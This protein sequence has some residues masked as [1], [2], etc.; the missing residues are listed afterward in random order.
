MID[1][2]VENII[3][4]KI[5]KKK[6]KKRKASYIPTSI[7]S[8]KPTTRYGDFRCLTIYIYK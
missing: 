6:K 4:S 8:F 7:E 3:P 2:K 1:A 5:I